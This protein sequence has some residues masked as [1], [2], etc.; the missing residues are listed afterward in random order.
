MKIGILLDPYGEKAPSGLGRSSLE[1]VRHL[2]QQNSTDTFSVYVRTFEHDQAQFPKNTSV[3]PLNV[4]SLWFSGG[5]RLRKNHDAYLFTTSVIPLTFFPKR[6]TVMALDFA[7]LNFSGQ[8]L[9]QRIHALALYCIHTV[10]FLKAEHIACISEATQRE[11]HRLFF[12]SKKKTHVVPYGPIYLGAQQKPIPVSVPFFFF[13]GVLKERKNVAGIIRA[14]ALF[15]SK[16][17]HSTYSLYI[18]GRTGGKYYESLLKLI[19]TLGLKTR[20]HFLGYVADEQLS[21]LYNHAHALVFPSFIEGFGMPVLEAMQRGLPVIT[22]VYGSLAEVAGDAA[23]LVDPHDPRA[24]AQAMAY[25][26]DDPSLRASLVERGYN[27]AKEFS[28]EKTAQKIS[29]LLRS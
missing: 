2:V 14:F 23:L 19:E 28:W 15:C 24:I 9:M 25:L 29:T 21:Y 3:K 22:S 18:A 4:S 20:V 26:A 1:L 7:Y 17:A 16:A 5:K 10:S 13:A 8:S 11:L 6:A 27:R 12:V